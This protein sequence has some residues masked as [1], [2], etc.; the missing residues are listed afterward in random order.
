MRNPEGL[1]GS[2][3]PVSSSPAPFRDGPGPRVSGRGSPSTIVSGRRPP[4][5]GGRVLEVG[6]PAAP[7]EDRHA[8]TPHSDAFRCLP[9]GGPD[10]VAQRG[11]RRRV[12]CDPANRLAAVTGRPDA[13][14][15]VLAARSRSRSARA[16]GAPRPV[17]GPASSGPRPEVGW[18][19]D[20]RLQVSS[21][22][23][24]PFISDASRGQPL[25]RVAGLA[26]R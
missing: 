24:L 25:A 7:A 10:G 1:P 11:I 20:S 17:D 6:I 8:A 2:P 26:P 16:I 9:R 19:P 13:G 5:L 23:G 15:G 14:T 3:R 21:N 4:D 22:D 12:D 18:T